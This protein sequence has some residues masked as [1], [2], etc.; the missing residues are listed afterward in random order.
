M[1]LTVPRLSLALA[2]NMLHHTRV[3]TRQDGP[4]DKDKAHG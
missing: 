4:K 2:R 3:Q 1:N